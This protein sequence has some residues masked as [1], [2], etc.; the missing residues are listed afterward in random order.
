MDSIPEELN[1]IECNETEMNRMELNTI[2]NITTAVLKMRRSRGDGVS[3]PHLKNHN[4]IGFLSNTGP[5]LLKN[6]KNYQVGVSLARQR[7]AI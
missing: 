6:K 3:G 5:D 2:C 4:Y 7:N 1:R